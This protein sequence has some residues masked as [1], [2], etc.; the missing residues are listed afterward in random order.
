MHKS[1]I[2][3]Q[4]L[5]KIRD[6]KI[7]LKD[8]LNIEIEFKYIYLEVLMSPDLKDYLI[9]YNPV[10][11][12]D[13]NSYYYLLY[14]FTTKMKI[15]DKL[16]LEK[17][18]KDFKYKFLRFSILKILKYYQIT[19]LDF[20][21][22]YNMYQN[23]EI[24]DEKL[25]YKIF[26]KINTPNFKYARKF[27]LRTNKKYLPKEYKKIGYINLR[28]IS[29]QL[30]K[31][32]IEGEVN[33]LYICKKFRKDFYDHADEEIRIENFI[34]DPDGNLERFLIKNYHFNDI[35]NI[36]YLISKM[37][38]CV[39]SYNL[40]EICTSLI[41]S[42][43]E[44]IRYL[45]YSLI[46]YY[47]IK[48]INIDHLIFDKSKRVRNRFVTLYKFVKL[49]IYDILGKKINPDTLVEYIKLRNI[50]LNKKRLK[51][52][53][54]QQDP[55]TVNNILR[56]SIDF[57]MLK[58]KKYMKMYKDQI[59][60]KICLYFYYKNKDI[61]KLISKLIREKDLGNILRLSK[62]LKDLLSSNNKFDFKNLIL[63]VFDKI[64]DTKLIIRRSGGLG[65][66]FKCIL[67]NKIHRTDNLNLIKKILIS[68]LDTKS[69]N[70][71]HIYNIFIEIYKKYKFVDENLLIKRILNNLNGSSFL[72]KNFS[73]RIFEI[74]YKK[75]DVLD[76][77]DE[78]V[79]ITDDCWFVFLVMIEKFM[80]YD[81]RL[82]NYTG[83]NIFIKMKLSEVQRKIS[84][85]KIQ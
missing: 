39:T 75:H 41:G 78:F 58:I 46:E 26:E 67:I 28:S 53:L 43:I 54:N 23:I 85:M 80:N 16:L 45:G 69:D 27:I 68:R 29:D 37:P 24:L 36:D 3:K 20:I 14:K 10:S 2:F 76:Y 34:N 31:N 8:I 40:S 62:Y 72:I 32:E 13:L 6:E 83:T 9:Q 82:L 51:N 81:V 33:E 55:T 71:Y 15:T 65:A 25:I 63:E 38:S 5:Q 22:K 74:I 1:E 49:D 11:N 60:K 50:K 17:C 59:S 64:D 44:N 19:D 7:E 47:D 84:K 57:N 42:H 12:T 18:M 21:M 79:C 30:N 48:T 4:I 77:I 70:L 56:I 61:D 35:K 52:L 66:I 73:L